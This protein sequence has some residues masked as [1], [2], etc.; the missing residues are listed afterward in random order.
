MLLEKLLHADDLDY[1]NHM[2]DC[3]MTGVPINDYAPETR[4]AQVIRGAIKR[5]RQSLENQKKKELTTKKRKPKQPNSPVN[6]CDDSD[7]ETISDYD[8]TNPEVLPEEEVSQ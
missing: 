4:K 5:K 1:Y 2:A 3:V 7:S 6:D 8:Y